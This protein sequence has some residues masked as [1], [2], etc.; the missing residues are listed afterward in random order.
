MQRQRPYVILVFVTLLFALAAPASAHQESPYP[1][2]T[3]ERT[4]PPKGPVQCPKLSYETYKGTTIPYHRSTK[5]YTGFKPHLQAFEEIARDVAIEIYG[6]APK[7]LVHMGTFNCRRIRSYPEFLSEHALGNAIDVAGFD[8]GPLPRGAALPEGA[9][10]WAKGGFKVR[11]DDHWDAKRRYKIHS[12]FLKRL[13]QKLI[14]RP[15]IF[16]SMLGPAW[17]GH[18]NHFHFDMSPWRTVAVFKEGRPD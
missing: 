2:D 1:L 18:H 4:V 9:P 6:R 7:R 13:A 15:E 16:R 17:P 8:F 11:M 5:I 10:K 12:R 3:I 14:R